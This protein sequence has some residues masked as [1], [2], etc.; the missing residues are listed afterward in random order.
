MKMLKDLR[1][2][3]IAAALAATMILSA[4]WGNIDLVKL[5]LRFLEGIE[6]HEADDLVSGFLLILAAIIID[7]V[8]CHR[9][10][11]RE[12]EVQA[13]KLRTLK[14]TM[15][16][17]QDIVNNFLNNLMV[18]ELEA[19]A[20]MPSESVDQLERLIHETSAKLKSLGNLTSVEEKPLAAGVGIAYPDDS[21]VWLAGECTLS[22]TP[23]HWPDPM[24][25]SRAWE[26]KRTP[27][28]AP[29][30]VSNVGRVLDPA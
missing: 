12:A 24:V 21:R 1:V 15:R 13:E 27:A 19:A 7:R 30:N 23:A 4:A 28:I 5:N 11:R 17:V 3:L 20:T 9:R 29:R 25:S 10:K 16:T 8:L 2:T 6:R 14:A 22:A 18:F 26:A